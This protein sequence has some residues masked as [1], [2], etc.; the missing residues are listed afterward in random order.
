[1][2]PMIA[3]F[4]LIVIAVVGAAVTKLLGDAEFKRSW[5]ENSAP[6]GE[7]R[8]ESWTVYVM[9]LA[10]IASGMASFLCLIAGFVLMMQAMSR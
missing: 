6:L 7:Y 9:G 2:S 8:P 3:G 10:T 5:D 4:L 1:M